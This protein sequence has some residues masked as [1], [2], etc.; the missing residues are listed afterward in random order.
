MALI[1]CSECGQTVSDRATA[2]PRCGNPISHAPQADQQQTS[3]GNVNW[4]YWL[5]GALAVL[6]VILFFT[7]ILPTLSSSSSNS[8]IA[9]S[10][11]TAATATTP[12]GG[13]PAAAD[14]KENQSKPVERHSASL[15]SND[16]RCGSESNSHPDDGSNQG[17]PMGDKSIDIKKTWLEHESNHGLKIH[18][19]MNASNL[20]N[21]KLKVQCTFFFKD[22]KKVTSTDGNYETHNRQV[23][24]IV[25]VNP[26]FQYTSWSDL[27]LWIPYS[28]IKGVKDR[29]HL[30]C[31]VEVYD[32]NHCLATSQYMH[33]DC[34]LY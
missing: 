32:G 8:H 25:T 27:Q 34:W 15:T 21:R 31:R 7:L 13:E 29:K 3:G 6:G 9:D 16:Y 30:K 12:G 17:S 2:C 4:L 19:N 10:T 5:I 1:R 33:F 26:D 22:G 23:G 24:T 18:V 11:A 20:L 14:F 28:Q